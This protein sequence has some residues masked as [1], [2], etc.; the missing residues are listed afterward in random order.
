[1]SV[2]VRRPKANA[3]LTTKHQ[4]AAPH[5]RVV[6]VYDGIIRSINL[7]DLAFAR[8][9]IDRLAEIDRHLQLA[10]QLIAELRAALDHSANETLA[11]TLDD[12]YTFWARQLSDANVAKQPEK[13]RQILP[14][15][16]DLRDAWYQA[17]L[18][19]EL[20]A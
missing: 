11:T 2:A 1:M 16:M 4:T 15:I 10:S 14:Q 13:M 5:H 19:L 6:L 9:D 8:T 7:A 20:Q 17:G 18:Q 3:Y 12:L